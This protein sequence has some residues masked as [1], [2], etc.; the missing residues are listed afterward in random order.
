MQGQG[1]PPVF[2]LVR[3]GEDLLV[4]YLPVSRHRHDVGMYMRCPLVQMDDEGEDVLLA[5]PAGKDAVHVLGPAL[6]LR[7]PLQVRIVGIRRIVH[8]LGA[9]GQG[10][11]RVVRAADDEVHDRTEPRV[12][13]AFLVRV[14]DASR[15]E[16]L[17]VLL[18]D[19]L[20]L[21]HRLHLPSLHDLEVESHPGPVDAS[22][23][24]R[25]LP[26][27]LRPAALMLVALG[28]G[29]ALLGL[30]VDDL[31]LSIHFSIRFY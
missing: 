23:L 22:V 31:F 24:V 16:V 30:E 8:L 17:L 5:E 4:V 2:V 10:A 15:G 7:T 11:Q 13:P 25:A 1:P 29:E 6:D 28:G 19:G 27:L 3:S 18:R 12:V 9:E 21:V 14:R 26:S 20:A